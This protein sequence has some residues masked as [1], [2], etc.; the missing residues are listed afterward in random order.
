[1]ILG[2]DTTTEHLHLALVSEGR[3]WTRRVGV[4]RG[5]SAS[6][7]LLPALDDLL[8]EAGAARRDLS[9]VCACVGP[10]G[11]TSL[12]LGVA[13]AEG[14]AVT[15]LPTWGFS[16]FALR[17]EALRT[18]GIAEAAWILLDGQRNEGFHQ[19]WTDQPVSEA[20]KTPM[21]ALGALVGGDAWWAPESVVPKLAPHLTSAPLAL[22]DEG[23][24]MLAGLVSLCGRLPRGTP[25]S[26]LHP[27]Y[28]RE[29]D[30]ELNF[31]DLSAHLTEA[32]RRGVAR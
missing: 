19:K 13:T 27:F 21:A 15:G 2:L 30:A 8:A 31:P 6:V 25:E 9:G 23:E 7:R 17:A 20:G 5:A 29:T 12:R 10:G 22:P 32:H 18:G 3:A 11:F 14:L 26:P 24:A 28:L 4:D 1:M 16:A